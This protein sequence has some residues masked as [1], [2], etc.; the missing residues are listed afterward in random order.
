MA[1]KYSQLTSGQAG[2]VGGPHLLTG[3]TRP[4]FALRA[5]TEVFQRQKGS[6]SRLQPQPLPLPKLAAPWPTLTMKGAIPYNKSI[7]TSICLSI[8]VCLD[9]YISA[10]LCLSINLYLST[11]ISTSIYLHIY[12]CVHPHLTPSISFL[13]RIQWQRIKATTGRMSNHARI[14]ME[15]KTQLWSSC[16]KGWINQTS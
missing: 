1:H 12:T 6:V 8:S 13:W 2:N 14:Q 5:N 10:Y 16:V 4:A 9:A 15:R 3:R 11:Y 7:P